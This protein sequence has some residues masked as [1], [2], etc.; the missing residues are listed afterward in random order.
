MVRFE[1]QVQM[2]Q[3]RVIES[4][5]HRVFEDGE[6]RVRII[7]SGEQTDGAY[8]LM[9]WTV[10]PFPAEAYAS[11]G[12]HVHGKYEETF[13]M[14]DGSL[15]FLLKD[16]VLPMHTGD[17]I[18]VSANMRHGYVNRSGKPARLLV[19]FRP[20]GMEELFFRHRTNQPTPPTLETFL[21]EAKRDHAS[22]YENHPVSA[23]KG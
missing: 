14:L 3:A 23:V 9:E 6:D 4:D 15:D 8:S 7:L 1:R 13:H 17:T 20:A 12:P 2:S 5:Q 16:R 21:N 11:F 22:E 10:A 18:I 19:T